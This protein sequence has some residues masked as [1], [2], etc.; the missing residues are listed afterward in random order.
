MTNI[1]DSF[2]GKVKGLAK[3]K[4]S[5]S[6]KSSFVDKA[7]KTKEEGVKKKA[8]TL[9]SS[10][11][12]FNKAEAEP[13]KENM[14][15]MFQSKAGLS[16]WE[17]KA[18]SLKDRRTSLK[19]STSISMT[20]GSD[21]PLTPQTATEKQKDEA[22]ELIRSG[23]LSEEIEEIKKEW[24]MEETKV[25]WDA[26]NPFL[27]Y[28]DAINNPNWQP[29]F[30][31][32]EEKW[33]K[34]WE[35]DRESLV[36]SLETLSQQS[37]LDQAEQKEKWIESQIRIPGGNIAGVFI[38]ESELRG[39]FPSWY[40]KKEKEYEVAMLGEAY[41]GFV[42]KAIDPDLVNV[43]GED[44]VRNAEMVRAIFSGADPKNLLTAMTLD[45][46]DFNQILS[47]GQDVYT[48]NG[49]I[50]YRGLEVA[51]DYITDEAKQVAMVSNT[52][53]R[54]GAG[55]VPYAGISGLIKGG[56][57][58][59]ARAKDLPRILTG[60]QKLSQSLKWAS[61]TAPILTEMTAFNT[62]EEIADIGIRKGTG[63]DY[64]FSDFVAGITIGAGFAGTIGLIG[65]NIDTVKL[66]Q[67]VR[68]MEVNVKDSKDINSLKTLEFEGTPLKDLWIGAREVYL[69]GTK[70]VKL[71]PGIDTAAPLPK[72]DPIEM[73]GVAAPEVSTKLVKIPESVFNSQK[74]VEV[75]TE[76]QTSAAGSRITTEE[77][78]VGVSSTFPDWVPSDLR[79]RALF[80]KVQEHLMNGT[81]PKTKK[82]AD[83]YRI[84]HQ[85]MLGGEG[86]PQIE[87]GVSKVGASMAE[88]AVSDKLTKTFGGTAEYSKITIEDQ[89]KQASDLVDKNIDQA[90]RILHGEE[91][92]PKGLRGASLL[93]ALE[94]YAV[95]T[96]DVELLRDIAKSPLTSETSIHAQELR[97]LAERDPFSPVTK[98]K[99]VISVRE[100]AV[101]K[102]LKG[103]TPIGIK[104]EMRVEL[105]QKIA[106]AKPTPKTWAALLDELTC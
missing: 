64:T 14:S 103:R 91:E 86:V 76:L 27:D 58:T 85:Q 10:L 99:E 39:A 30:E 79:T 69:K 18:K 32:A 33:N 48:K 66:K 8:E 77:G 97:L 72:V 20:G 11:V 81:V 28:E 19:Y 21:L 44:E 9:K 42:I 54:I 41:G 34:L 26:L 65:K 3:S 4:S 88:K 16:G 89:A 84:I 70:N 106:K 61:E 55:F 15:I 1:Y 105:S 67:L 2:L 53:G 62:L 17:Q 63:Q 13:T 90:L 93:T 49:K 60:V 50:Y 94:D 102:K 71:R 51:D 45:T 38:S 82:A 25:R 74:G 22:K 12:T 47:L 29:W 24:L 100:A 95:K 7:V 75:F 5:T 57:F 37:M 83:L 43:I 73:G 104:K 23:K 35:S 101:T 78:T 98:I 87:A 56:V 96:K 68:D 6:S 36:P 92:L 52:I 46:V 80:D 59:L 31:N 40:A